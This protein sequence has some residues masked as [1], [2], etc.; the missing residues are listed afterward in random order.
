VQFH[1]EAEAA[2][3]TAWSQAEGPASPAA[4]AA[5]AHIAASEAE[6]TATWRPFAERFVTLGAEHITSR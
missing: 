4:V 6:L 3:V 1:P 5:I 2:I